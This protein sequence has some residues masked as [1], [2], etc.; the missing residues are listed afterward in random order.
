V[1]PEYSERSR[2]FCTICRQAC[3]TC[4][5]HLIVHDGQLHHVLCNYALTSALQAERRGLFRDSDF[6]MFFI[7]QNGVKWG[8]FE[9]TTKE[10]RGE[11]IS[12]TIG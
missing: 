4:A 2:L 3:C 12:T 10:N 8:H 6:S 7:G 9:L 11:I 1:V 5:C